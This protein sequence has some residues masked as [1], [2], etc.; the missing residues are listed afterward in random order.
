MDHQK[1]IMIFFFLTVKHLVYSEDI[2]N[3][4]TCG[5]GNCITTTNPTLPY[6]CQCSNGFN[7]ILPCPSENP[8]SRNPCGQGTCEVVPKLLYGY[9]CRCADDII[10]LTNCNVTHNVCASN[11]CING[12]CIEGLTSFICHCLPTW[13]GRICNEKIDSSC[14]NNLCGIGKCFQINDPSLPYVC[15]CPSG[16]LAMS[17]QNIMYLSASSLARIFPSMTHLSN[18]CN[19]LNSQN[20]M[21]GG[22]CLLT[23]NGYQCH[24]N[25]GF[26]GHFCETNTDQCSSNPCG[27]SGVCYDLRSSYICACSDGSFRSQCLPNTGSLK[28]VENLSCPCQNN[29]ECTKISSQPCTCP[30][31]FTGRFCENLLSSNSCRQVQ[32]LNHGT[33]YENL[34]GLSVSPYCLCKSGYTGKY[35]E[36]EYFRCQLNGRFTDQYNCAKGKYFE[37]IHYGYDGPNKNGILLSR[38][39]QASL[40][41]NVLTDQCDYST[42]V[43]CIEN[44]TEHSLF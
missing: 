3:S 37:C 28:T 39:C 34:P 7:T 40:R 32:C 12:I 30:N 27:N 19:P 5:S 17:C 42:N 14:S 22:Q 29:G 18:I 33:C 9:L 13:T 16:Q 36:I 21:N 6:Y 26:T 35:C 43:Q 20:C 23:I 11:P 31:G 38:N 1:M 10:S 2:C 41:Y 44:E 15:L 4:I 25:S 24:C 8:C